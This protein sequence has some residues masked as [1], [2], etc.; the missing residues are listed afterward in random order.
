[1]KRGADEYMVALEVVVR[2]IPAGRVLSY[3][4]VADRLP[5]PATARQVGTW[6]RNIEDGAPWWRVVAHDGSFPIHR[7]DPR[8]A[9]TQEELLREEDTGFASSG[10]V[11]R[12]AFLQD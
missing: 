7:R 3:G 5:F 9:K 4:D 10:R 2:A 6:M 1:M 12:I 8:L 11:A